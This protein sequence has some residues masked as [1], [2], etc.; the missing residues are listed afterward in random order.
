MISSKLFTLL[1][2]LFLAV[3]PTYV[4]SQPGP[5]FKLLPVPRHITLQKGAELR[6]ELLKSIVLPGDFDRQ[7]LPPKLVRLS[8]SP[9]AGSYAVILRI[10]ETEN[11]PESDE[12]YL[13]EVKSNQVVIS[14]RRS[15][16]LFYGC[17]TLNQLIEDA[18]D[19]QTGIPA[20]T[21]TDYPEIA[22]RGV[23]WDLKHH[24]DS[25]SYYYRMIDRL[26]AL[27][28]NGLII[29]FEDKLKYEKAPVIGSP[30]ALSIQQFADLSRYAKARHIEVSPLVQG[31]GHVPFILKHPQY[32]H[33]RDNPDSDWAF[34]ALNPGTYD[35]QFALYD[36]AIKATPHG[37]YLHIGGD[38]VGELG[39]SELARKSGMKPFELQM[40]W[41]NKVSEYAKSKNR[42]PIFWDDMIFQLSGL[43][44]TTYDGSLP[45]EKAKELWSKNRLLLDEN[46]KL[47]PE[48]C[49]YMRWNYGGQWVWGNRQALDWYNSKNLKAM[50][51]TAAQTNWMLMPRHNSNISAIKGFSEITKEKA[52]EG[53]LCTTWE[54]ASP[55]ME[56]FMRGFSFFGLYSWGADGVSTEEANVRFRH[57]FY[58][59]AV[60][61]EEFEF[62]DILEEALSF[63]ETGLTDRGERDK[64][65]R[66]F[67]LIRLPDRNVPGEWRLNYR[68]KLTLARQAVRLYNEA[69]VKIDLTRARATRNTYHLDLL[70]SINELQVYPAR[71]ILLLESFDHA[72][73]LEKAASVAALR[74]CVDE[75]AALRQ[76]FETI[77]SRTRS[78]NMPD[79]YLMDSN[80]KHPHMANSKT[81]DW[82]YRFELAMNKKMEEWFRNF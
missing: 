45:E 61:P 8:L 38:E 79:D 23:H 21:I 22:Y 34:C 64:P 73:T 31:L 7:I 72:P 75:F 41:L 39:A 35:L 25:L 4:Q 37:K 55:H 69:K 46:L 18:A 60:G 17:Q 65:R 58:G 29:E 26:A 19:Q 74:S 71:L 28:I 13:L 43:Y 59:P 78:L 54:D 52:L 20:C 27:K 6:P 10:A 36:D 57:R 49:I 24:I 77:F 48:N 81:S 68:D 32:R 70:Q 56:T 82:M 80:Q 42:I 62:Q 63:W 50:A 47:F 2:V 9:K 11:I 12:G 33:L 51:A 16:G 66:P 15:A 53:I 44:R 5:R 67:E 1:T 40:Y 30:D 14:A 3:L 76:N